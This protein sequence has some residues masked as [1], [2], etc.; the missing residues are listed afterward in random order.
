MADDNKTG[1]P[2]AP[3]PAKAI[4]TPQLPTKNVRDDGN[5]LRTYPPTGGKK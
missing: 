3:N 1:N 4:S 2:P 5:K